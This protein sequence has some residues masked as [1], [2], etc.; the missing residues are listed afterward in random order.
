MRSIMKNFFF[1]Y[2]SFTLN[3]FIQVSATSTQGEQ[4]P[5]NNG[6]NSESTYDEQKQLQEI[7]SDEEDAESGGQVDKIELIKKGEVQKLLMQIP[8]DFDL[9][10]INGVIS[11]FIYL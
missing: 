5:L 10:E 3:H 4:A 1:I 2:I 7:L 11:L 8:P 6:A 9:A